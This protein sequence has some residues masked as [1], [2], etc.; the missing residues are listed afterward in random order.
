MMRF[1]AVATAAAAA[2]LV[3]AFILTPISFAASPQTFCNPLNLDYG[4]RDKGGTIHRHGA[5]PV[6]TLYNNRYYLF[7]TW[8]LPGYRVSDDLLT[9]KFIPFAGELEGRTY[10]A[11]ATMVMD[12]WLYFTE[13][14]RKNGPP[15]ALWRTRNPES[16]KWDKVRH[17]LPPYADPCLFVDPK[18]GRVFMYSGLDAPT[19]GVE[20]DRKA[21][22]EIDGTDTQLMPAFDPKQRIANGWEVCTWDNSEVSKG[23][24]GNKTFFPCR[25]G[26][27][28]TYRDGRYYL[29][30]ASPGTTVPGYADGLLTGESPLG[31]FARSPYSPISRKPSGFISSAGHGCLFQDRYGNWWRAVTMLI[32]VHERMERRIGLF[33]AGFDSDGVPY[34]RTELDSP[35]T[36]PTGPRD[37]A[38][39]DVWTTW[40]NL[41]PAAKVTASSSPDRDHPP[42]LAN[43]ED[44]RTWWSAKTGGSDEWLQL[45]FGDDQEIRAAQVNLAEQGCTPGAKDEGH[46]FKLL[47]SNDAVQWRTVLDR[48][49]NA[50]PSPHTYVAFDAPVR[51]RH[52]RLANL[53][54]PAGGNFAVS[55][56]RLF[57]VATG[58]P[59][60]VVKRLDATRDP[61]DRRKVALTW[62]PADRATAY[63]I[64]YGIAKKQLYQHELIVGGGTKMYTLYC[65]NNDPPYVFTIES[66]NNS[67]RTPSPASATIP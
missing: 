14:G 4:L 56:L 49:D 45:D 27:W 53:R 16:G 38:S 2:A 52:F 13:F 23:M 3:G 8:D 39:D 46:R 65:L 58:R 24:R 40:W 62:T 20:L 18:S 28:M 37:H 5:D 34:T 35:I 11:A 57:G 22:T 47:A 21:F 64:R 31:P 10:T 44:I 50:V 63:L 19:R 59:P 25:E 54:T 67:G 9:W 51:A 17:H 48:S 12:G 29:Q 61:G 7:S 60:G 41:S 36:L 26:A 15:V 33:P 6:I 66:L 43:D 42:V 55:D 32:G 1:V 30:F